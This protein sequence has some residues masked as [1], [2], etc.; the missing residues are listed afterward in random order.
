MQKL[1]VLSH[2]RPEQPF[3]TLNVGKSLNLLR[4]WDSEENAGIFSQQ[5]LDKYFEIDNFTESDDITNKTYDIVIA[6]G[7]SNFIFSKYYES[8]KKHIHSNTKFVLDFVGE[9]DSIANEFGQFESV[10]ELYNLSIE[11]FIIVSCATNLNVLYDE[12]CED[13]NISKK[14]TIYD[15]PYLQFVWFS[16]FHYAGLRGFSDLKILPNYDRIESDV[17]FSFL[18]GHHQNPRFILLSL[19]C[20]YIDSKN[21]ISYNC[22]SIEPDSILEDDSLRNILIENKL[23]DV[24]KKII[25]K[26]PIKIDLTGDDWKRYYIPKELWD[27]SLFSI[28]VETNPSLSDD[29]KSKTIFSTEK[30]HNALLNY[31]PFIVFGAKKYL[32][33][34]YILGFKT[35]DGFFD[36]S[37]DSEN[38]GLDRLYKIYQDINRICNTPHNKLKS[39]VQNFHDI[40]IHNINNFHN[41]IDNHS[42]RIQKEILNLLTGI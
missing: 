11:N 13:N 38:V 35:Y 18:N 31:R 30:V 19:L 23:L 21:I 2:K 29:A 28:I 4:S 7:F 20:D 27:K 14:L 26:L 16:N 15:D 42:E 24:S 39:D 12:Y 17:Y 3:P 41:I 33:Y 32:E 37:Y 25:N 22:I 34:L 6:F 1:K 10:V 9:G 5:Q 8:I 40:Y 36:E